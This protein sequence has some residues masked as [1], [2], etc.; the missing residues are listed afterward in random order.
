MHG[1]VYCTERQ[2]ISKALNPIAYLESVNF[3][4]SFLKLRLYRYDTEDEIIKEMHELEVR[5]SML[6][7]RS[8]LRLQPTLFG[9]AIHTIHCR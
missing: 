4:W 5:N 2:E 8:Y 3:H 1:D 9:I 7:P 6:L